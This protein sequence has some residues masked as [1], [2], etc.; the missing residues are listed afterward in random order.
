MS[1]DT[2]DNLKL[3]MAAWLNRRDL[4]AIIP[5]FISLQEAQAERK[6][7]TRE[8]IARSRAI[9]DAE[10]ITLPIDFLAI[11]HAIV[12]SEKPSVL[13]WVPMN[14]IDVLQAGSSPGIPTNY[15]IIGDELEFS[16]IPADD[17]EIEVVY[18]GRIPRLTTTNQTNW[19]LTRHPD[20]YL[21]GS[22]MQAA[23]YL[24]ND[25]RVAI[26]ATALAS[27]YEDIR[28]AD[29]KATKG[30]TPLKMRITPY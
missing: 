27:L 30:G 6:I 16:P 2:Y 22:L 3:E 11:Q 5:T 28:L 15:T 8:M 10:F 12:N 26:W 25:E 20:I 19:L 18:Y 29:E 21:Y 24:K 9:A 4:T 23:P 13:E 7:R 17:V 1:L 14:E